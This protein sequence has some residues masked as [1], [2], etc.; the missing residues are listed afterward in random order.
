MYH[1]DVCTAQSAT[2]W[3]PFTLAAAR[4]TSGAG[5]A[6]AAGLRVAPAAAD[7]VV[8]AAAAGL[9]DT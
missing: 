6:G 4:E 9:A 2:L 1:H 3:L 8:A 7:E 5:G